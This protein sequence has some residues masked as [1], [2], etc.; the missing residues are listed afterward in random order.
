MPSG[1]KPLFLHKI[2]ND[3]RVD[4]AAAGSHF[5]TVK[6]SEAH[7][8]IDALSALYGGD[9][10]AVSDVAGDDLCLL[11]GLVKQLCHFCGNK[12]VG[13]SVRTV[14]ADPVFLC[15]LVFDGIG[16]CLFGHGLMERGVENKDLR[17]IRHDLGAAFNA[18]KMSRSVKRCKVVAEHGASQRPP[19]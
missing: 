17:N 1:M 19:E 2:G 7:G 18:H 16:A 5:D 13:G 12:T 11:N 10:R 8:G 15:V 3:G 6:G 4:G 14:A 9:G